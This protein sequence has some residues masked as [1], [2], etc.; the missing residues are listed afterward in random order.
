MS[1]L[2]IYL[3]VVALFCVGLMWLTNPKGPKGL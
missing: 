3:F 2:F 1:V